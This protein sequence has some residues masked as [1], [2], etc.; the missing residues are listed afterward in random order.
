MEDVLMYRELDELLAKAKKG[1]V[2]SKEEILNRLE[3]LIIKSIQRYYNI[4]NEYEDLIQLGNLVILECIQD[5][6]P[7]KKVYFLGYVKTM[8]KYAYLNRHKERRHLSLNTPIG[9]D[10]DTEMVDTLESNME[11]PLEIILKLEDRK[12]LKNALS[13]LTPRQREVTLAYYIEGL[14]M[15]DIAERL[16]ISYRTVVNTKTRSLEIMKRSI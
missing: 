2:N 4:K 14:S 11:T 16:G 9:K 10:G 7:D 3:G 1:D 12:E 8:L 13:S 15:A 5:Y 6:N